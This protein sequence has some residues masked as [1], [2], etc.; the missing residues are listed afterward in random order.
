[1][2]YPFSTTDKYKAQAF[3]EYAEHNEGMEFTLRKTGNRYMAGTNHNYDMVV[4]RAL[5]RNFNSDWAIHS[6]DRD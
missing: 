6:G 3:V 5:V 2:I 1:M 4:M